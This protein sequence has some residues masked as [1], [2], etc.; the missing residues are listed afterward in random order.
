[1]N[2]QIYTDINEIKNIEKEKNKNKTRILKAINLIDDFV[3]KF[4]SKIEYFKLT[5]ES[6]LNQNQLTLINTPSLT[7]KNDDLK[8]EKKQDEIKENEIEEKKAN[9]NINDDAENYNDEYL[10]K[11]VSSKPFYKKALYLLYLITDDKSKIEQII[12]S[13]S[14]SDISFNK[15]KITNQFCCIK[16]IPTKNFINHIS[17]IKSQDLIALGM[18]NFFDGSSIDLYSLDLKIKLSLK[19]LG[20]NI[21]ELQSG[22]LVTCSYNTIN[23]IK[24]E[25]NEQNIKYKVLQTL[26]GKTDSGEILGLIELNSFIISYD[27]N[28]ILIWKSYYPNKNNKKKKGEKVYKYKEYKYSNFGSDYLLSLNNT[29]FIS[30]EKGNLIIFNTLDNFDGENRVKI[31]GIN[32]IGDSMCL[33]DKY[34]ILIIG[35]NENGFLFI[36]SVENKEIIDT[37]KINDI[38]NYSI[39][40]ILLYNTEDKLNILCAGGY[41]TTDK[42]IVSDL[43]KITFNINK[44]SK[45]IFTI[46]QQDIV[47]NAHN[48]WITG[49]LIKNFSEYKE[50]NCNIFDNYFTTSN[51]LN[52][53]NIFFTTSHDKK[54]KIWSYNNSKS[55]I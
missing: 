39:N 30:H 7:Q 44:N 19:K 14:N 6:K 24:L 36:I 5:L 16:E 15:N 29:E 25:K 42:N 35:G 40:K 1:M 11:F 23:I 3:T 43:F 38:S 31:K 53:N 47:K 28:H 4:V 55:L 49:L 41:N 54:I 9:I 46:E 51:I 8:K 32:S 45:Q 37:I 2:N 27:W 48:S 50:K 10:N 26:K 21:Y 52:D 34:K 17:Y 20:S 13:D 18:Y 33:I 22:D 12:K